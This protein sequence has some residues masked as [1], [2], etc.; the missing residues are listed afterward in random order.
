MI[1]LK[2]ACEQ[3]GLLRGYADTVYLDDNGM[4]RMTYPLANVTPTHLQ[5]IAD[6]MKRGLAIY[7]QQREE[8]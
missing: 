7:K 3:A 4:I 1:T 6:I 2:E 8:T 5:A